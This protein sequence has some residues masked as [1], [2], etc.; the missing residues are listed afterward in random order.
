MFGECAHLGHVHLGEYG[1]RLQR[2]TASLQSRDRGAGVDAVFLSATLTLGANLGDS[3]GLPL[4]DRGKPASGYQQCGRVF[5]VL[6]LAAGPG[7][8]RARLCFA[9]PA[10]GLT[11]GVDIGHIRTL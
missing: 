8:V 10:S 3:L 6:A 4:I 1:N 2:F 7:F 11:F 9:D 5:D